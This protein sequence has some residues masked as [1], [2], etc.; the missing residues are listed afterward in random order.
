VKTVAGIRGIQIG[1]RRS[2]G[3]TELVIVVWE[4][5]AAGSLV[6]RE[7]DHGSQA[8]DRFILLIEHISRNCVFSL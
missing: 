6:S 8:D 4:I 5:K 1:S 3:G 7:L 2:R